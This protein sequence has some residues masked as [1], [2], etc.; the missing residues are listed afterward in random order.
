MRNF[1][2]EQTSYIALSSRSAGLFKTNFQFCQLSKK[3]FSVPDPI[4]HSYLLKSIY[5]AFVFAI[6]SSLLGGTVAYAQLDQGT[7]AGTV[8]DSTDAAIP[9]VTVTLVNEATGLSLVR[10]ADGAGI[11]TFTPIKIGSYTVTVSAQGFSTAVQKGI[12]V[13][14]S[15]R[16]EVPITLA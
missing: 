9:N 4:P 10:T 16:I 7:L 1:N 6:I 12:I 2:T 3:S 14:A 11:F 8:R 5:F 15:S 13:N